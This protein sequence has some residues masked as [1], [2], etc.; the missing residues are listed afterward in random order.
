M[1]AIF[2]SWVASCGDGDDCPETLCPAP[3]IQE[4]V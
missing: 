3:L 1:T 2:E 4:H